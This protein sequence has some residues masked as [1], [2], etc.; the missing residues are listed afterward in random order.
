MSTQFHLLVVVRL[1]S[2]PDRLCRN[3]RSSLYRYLLCPVGEA[4]EKWK[5]QPPYDISHRVL[6]AHRHH[7]KRE[8]TTPNLTQEL[9]DSC[10]V[11]SRDLA[12]SGG[13][14]NSSQLLG[15]GD[16]ATR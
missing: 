2:T 9:T 5:P 10:P 12:R 14:D 13:A 6:W 15:S 8:V 1:V 11:E 7:R 16:P 3:L 4:F